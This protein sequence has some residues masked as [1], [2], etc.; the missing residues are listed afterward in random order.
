MIDKI[1]SDAGD[2]APE[3]A[4]TGDTP[5]ANSNPL[6]ALEW[7]LDGRSAGANAAGANIEAVIGEPSVVKRPRVRWKNGPPGE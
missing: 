5:S 3:A 2:V 4:A 6:R 7:Y 1:D